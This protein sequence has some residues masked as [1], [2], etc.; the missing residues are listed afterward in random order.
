MEQ[1]KLLN[2]PFKQIFHIKDM[3]Y[4]FFE[5]ITKQIP[6]IIVLNSKL[7]VKDKYTR[8]NITSLTF[9]QRI[10]KQ[11]ALF[12]KILP[13]TQSTTQTLETIIRK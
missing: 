10:F 2:R 6:T 12:V 4:N 1:V 3:N 9:F 13:Y 8:K 11:L 5:N 7:H